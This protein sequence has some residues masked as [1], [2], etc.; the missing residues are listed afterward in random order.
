MAELKESQEYII[1]DRKVAK[2][3]L[4]EIS[5]L[6][7]SLKFT[8]KSIKSIKWNDD[9]YQKEMSLQDRLDY[10]TNK[11]DGIYKYLKLGIG[12]EF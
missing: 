3:L 7:T 9:I 1:I 4:H 10:I 6:E 5:H 11:L 2:N 12:E 8:P